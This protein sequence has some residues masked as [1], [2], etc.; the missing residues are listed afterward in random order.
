MYLSMDVGGLGAMT[1]FRAAAVQLA[2]VVRNQRENVLKSEK[3]QGSIAVVYQIPGGLQDLEDR[4]QITHGPWNTA[5]RRQFAIVTVP[6]ELPE[7]EITD[8]LAMTFCEASKS[9]ATGRSLVRRHG[10]FSFGVA[11]AVAAKAVAEYRD[12]PSD[13]LLAAREDLMRSIA[14]NDQRIA[15]R[16]AAATLVSICKSMAT[17]D[18]EDEMDALRGQ[19]VDEVRAS[20]AAVGHRRAAQVNRNSRNA[21]TIAGRA[22]ETRGRQP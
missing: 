15:D 12:T 11:L 17:S 22:L 5:K 6:A 4:M 7:H 21:D 16:V 18:F 14:E 20:W 13:Q 8:F 3:S 1:Y 10:G 9:R 19:Y 2:T